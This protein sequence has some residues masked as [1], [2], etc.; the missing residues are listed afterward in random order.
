MII[1]MQGYINSSGDKPVSLN[2]NV[3]E[4]LAFSLSNGDPTLQGTRDKVFRPIAKTLAKLGLTAD[5]LSLLGLTFAVFAA[6]S[7]A[8]NWLL[9]AGIFLS[10]SLLI[11]GLDGVVARL[12]GSAN[13]RGELLDVFCDTAGVLSIMVGMTEAGFVTVSS[14]VLYAV[15]LALYTIVSSVKSSILIGNTDRSVRELS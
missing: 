3:L 11:D 13:S 5:L 6:A 4:R 7:V 14:L 2:R 8:C 10:L 12:M 15:S 1:G 9:A